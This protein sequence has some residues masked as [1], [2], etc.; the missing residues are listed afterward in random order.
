[1]SFPKEYEDYEETKQPAQWTHRRVPD[2]YAK[3]MHARGPF[4]I[5]MTWKYFACQGAE[6]NT[7]QHEQVF[8]LA[9]RRPLI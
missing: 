7:M 8:Y 9:D 3:V 5:M 6:F 1:M 2:D 4:Q